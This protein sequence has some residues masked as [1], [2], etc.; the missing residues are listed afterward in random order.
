MCRAEQAHL[1]Q[2]A[3][4]FEEE[5]VFV[6]VSNRDTVANGKAYRD[7]FD[8]PYPLAHGPR[9]WDRYDVAYQPVTIVIGA[10]GTVVERID[11][12]VSPEPFR[13]LLRAEAE[14]AG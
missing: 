1:N 4:E 13:R 5:I 8:V 12:P 7:E 6:G 10:D 11:G 14:R 2:L 3:E 9:V